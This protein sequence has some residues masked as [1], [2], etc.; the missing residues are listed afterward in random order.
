MVCPVL[1]VVEILWKDVKY[2]SAYIHVEVEANP[3]REERGLLRIGGLEIAK[4]SASLI[5]P[6][7]F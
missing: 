2:V 1:Y 3:V 4:L 5:S 6:L 7:P